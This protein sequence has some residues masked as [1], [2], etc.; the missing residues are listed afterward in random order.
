MPTAPTVLTAA[1]L[2]RILAPLPGH[3]LIAMTA[4]A[5]GN[6]FSPVADALTYSTI[7]FF[8]YRTH[9]G[10]T[11]TRVSAQGIALS[12]ARA[13]SDPEQW[14]TVQTLQRVLSP[15]PASMPVFLAQNPSGNSYAPVVSH[16]MELSYMREAIRRDAER[17]RGPICGCPCLV[18]IPG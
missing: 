17:P 2:C 8:T 15:L 14:T 4:D 13:A 11:G 1:A 5:E 12:P 6:D 10:R 7:G 9:A 16:H 18:L 3:R